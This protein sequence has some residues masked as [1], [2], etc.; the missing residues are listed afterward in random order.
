MRTLAT[1]SR[2]KCRQ[3]MGKATKKKKMLAHWIRLCY[4]L[5]I[6]AAAEQ[7][8]IVR[9]EAYGKQGHGPAEGATLSGAARKQ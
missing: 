9:Q 6:T 3:Y 1:I 7:Q 4:I 5:L 8:N 2:R